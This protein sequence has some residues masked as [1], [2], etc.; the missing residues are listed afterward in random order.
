MDE[1]AFTEALIA[2]IRNAELDK[3]TGLEGCIFCHAAGFIGGHKTKAG[4]LAML[5]LALAAKE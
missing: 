3:I 1:A 4:A 5:E 2:G